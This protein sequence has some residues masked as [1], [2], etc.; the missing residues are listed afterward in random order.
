MLSELHLRNVGPAPAFDVEL[1]DR[2]NVFTGDNSLGK[3]FLLDIAWWMMTGSWAAQPILPAKA[4]RSDGFWLL[5][6]IWVKDQKI[7][8]SYSFANQV[9]GR[10]YAKLPPDYNS[11]VAY[12]RVDGGFSVWDPARNDWERR[13]DL[14]DQWD[15]DEVRPSNYSFSPDALWQ[16]LESRGTVLC[17]GLLRDW[18][19]WQNQP[20]QDETSPFQLLSRVIAGLSHPEEAM[21]PGPPQRMSVIDARDVP[22]LELP[23]GR[24]PLINASAGIKRIVNLAYLLVW[25]WVEH[26]RAAELRGLEPV[27][28]LTLLIDEVESHLH[29]RWQRAILPSLLTISEQLQSKLRSQILATTHAPLV[30]ASIEPNFD[31]SRDKLFHFKLDGGNVRLDEVPWA[32]EG[33]A[34]NWLTSDVF[35][36]AQARSREAEVAIEAAEAL[37]RGDKAALPAGLRTRSAIDKKLKRLLPGHDPFWPRWIVTAPKA[38]QA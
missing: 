22:T 28:H 11:L 26:T 10:Q 2:L 13:E 6:A 8:V 36:L 38:R 32:K 17:N 35:G 20:K 37:M 31:P 34:V 7:T 18:V 3:T 15:F 25:A 29:P 21:K 12:A 1:A 30:L 23:Y 9:W 33:D 27:K 14:T 4:R 5:P 16:G 19:N 24:I